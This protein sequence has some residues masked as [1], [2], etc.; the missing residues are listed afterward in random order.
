[1]RRIVLDPA[2]EA[3]RTGFESLAVVAA[4]LEGVPDA[5]WRVAGGWMVRAWAEGGAPNEPA[6]TT[7]DVDLALFP[8][9][10]RPAI[11]QVP[12][13]L[14]ADGLRPDEEPFRLRRPD[15]VLV[16]LLAPPGASRADPPRIGRQTLFLAEGAAFGFAL[17]PEPVE[18][19]LG[20]RR[21]DF[22]VA[23]LAAALVHKTIALAAAR[24]RYL[25][26][27]SDVARLLRVVRR[28]PSEALFDLQAHRRRS[29]VG[30]AL[31]ALGNVFGDEEARGAVWVEQELGTNA[32]LIAVDDARW[33]SSTLG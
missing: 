9:R 30:R 32:A 6:R 27:A 1:M 17:P 10:G 22:Q 33:L 13:R 29:D 2:S 25:V 26:D 4:A 11:D 18:A 23:R 3:D 21:I 5:A 16:D 7:T 14:A 19:R 8:S 12:G 31:T 28:D 24:P 15:G 20:R